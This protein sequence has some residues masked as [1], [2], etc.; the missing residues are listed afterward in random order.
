VYSTY[1]PRL[2]DKNKVGFIPPDYDITLDEGDVL[3]VPKHFWHFVETL[4]AISLSINLWLPYPMPIQPSFLKTEELLDVKRDKV[5]DT[6]EESRD[7]ERVMEDQGGRIKSGTVANVHTVRTASNISMTE[8]SITGSLASNKIDVQNKVEKDHI[9]GKYNRGPSPC[10]DPQSRVMEA[11]SR[12]LYGALKGSASCVFDTDC[13]RS[14]WL[15]PSEQGGTLDFSACYSPLSSSSREECAKNTNYGDD[16]DDVGDDDD[17][18]S[19]DRV[20]SSQKVSDD[21]SD[22]GRSDEGVGDARFSKIKKWQ[23]MNKNTRLHLEYLYNSLEDQRKEE[24][25][26][27]GKGKSKEEGNSREG[28]V[29]YEIDKEI[30]FEGFLKRFFNALLDPETVERCLLR[31]INNY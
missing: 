8:S 18:D 13:P 29:D 26:E 25:M 20:R 5:L 27:Q 21:D 2:C 1:D 7:R 16:D 3:F 28:R 4:G 6:I 15:N 30:D 12:V 23:L 22:V 10:F 19:N 9:E 24:R 31:S 17:G 14:G 11:L